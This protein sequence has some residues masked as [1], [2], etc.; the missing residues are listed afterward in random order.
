M[1]ERVILLTART[2]NTLDLCYLRLLRQRRLL[3]PA[4]TIVLQFFLVPQLS[5][6]FAKITLKEDSH[7]EIWRFPRGYFLFSTWGRIISSEVSFDSSE[8]LFVAYVENFHFPRGDWRISTWGMVGLEVSGV[9]LLCRAFRIFV[10]RG[11]LSQ[12]TRAHMLTNR[13]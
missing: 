12:G 2:R 4:V 11:L 10:G 8:V 9:L 5:Y 3:A 1:Q 7:V 13:Y 6:Y